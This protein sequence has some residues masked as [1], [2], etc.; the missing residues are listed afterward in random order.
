MSMLQELLMVA[1]HEYGN[2]GVGV[3]GLIC[4]DNKALGVE[5]YHFNVIIL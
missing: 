1:I 5:P 4:D 2:G 3:G